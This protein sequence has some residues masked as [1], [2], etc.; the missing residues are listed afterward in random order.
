MVT[1]MKEI[2]SSKGWRS[3]L[4]VYNRQHRSVWFLLALMIVM[5]IWFTN[6]KAWIV[7][8][9]LM[10]A[11]SAVKGVRIGFV[12]GVSFSIWFAAGIYGWV[13]PGTTI[14]R[15][16]G[17]WCIATLFLLVVWKADEREQIIKFEKEHPDGRV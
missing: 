1:H 5:S 12:S 7:F 2:F 13:M 17:L 8:F 15:V 3:E 4:D 16:I 11:Y 9:G 6:P 14:N 10:A